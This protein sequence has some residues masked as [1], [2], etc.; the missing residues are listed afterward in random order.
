M[1][2][3]YIL[4][5]NEFSGFIHL[6]DDEI[7]KENEIEISNEEF[8]R[9]ISIG[10]DIRYNPRLEKLD[11]TPNPD[12]NILKEKF[13]IEKWE[14]IDIST[15]EEKLEYYKQQIIFLTRELIITETAGFRDTKS[16]KKLEE[17][18]ARHME[19]SHELANK[20]NLT[21]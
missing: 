13:D 7:L 12:P 8:E 2:I 20:M 21:N 3:A 17:T 4:K 18:K 5:N 9:L 1:K 14:W 15:L 16:E 10:G 19:L 11:I 6:E